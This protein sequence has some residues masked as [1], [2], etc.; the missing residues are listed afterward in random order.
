M[1]DQ[2]TTYEQV[3]DE[4]G[5]KEP[6]RWKFLVYMSAR[7]SENE[8]VNCE[9]HYAHLWAHRFKNESEW[10]YADSDGRAILDRI[11]GSPPPADPK[12]ALS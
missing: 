6:H 3:A 5:L 1:P 11:E 12:G 10:E 9:T 2:P 8:T 7:W 4:I